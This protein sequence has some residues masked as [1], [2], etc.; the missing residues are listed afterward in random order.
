MKKRMGELQK[1]L[2]A[3]AKQ[4][5]Q[6]DSPSVSD[7]TYDEAM[8]EL[9]SL[10]AQYPQYKAKKSITDSIGYVVLDKFAKEKHTQKM[11]SLGNAYNYEQLLAFDQRVQ[12]EIGKTAYVV[13]L[14]IDGL[15]MSIIYEE[16]K[17]KKAITRGDGV[18]GENV[19]HNIAT[20]KSLPKNISIENMTIRG[21]VY[22]TKKTLEKLN[23]ERLKNNLEP[24]ANC[25][26]AAAGS[27]RQLDSKVA[28]E[29]NLQAFWYQ[30]VDAKNLVDTQ[31][32]MLEK[33]QEEGFSVNPKSKRCNT[34]E[35]VITYIK[36][37]EKQRFDFPYDID[38]IVIKVDNLKNQEKLGNTIKVPK[39][40]IA[41]KFPAEEV[42][43]ILEDIII[44]VGRTGKI[45]PTGKLRPVHIAGT[46]VSAAQLHNFDL[47]EAKDIRIN[48]EVIVRKAGEIIPEIVESKK[49]KR[50]GTQK[51]Y[52]APINC[53]VCDTEIVRDEYEVDYYCLNNDCPARI[54][55]SLIHFASKDAMN[56]DGFGDKI[57]ELFYKEQL[58]KTVEDI[59]LLS[60]K[61]D[62]ILNLPGFKEKSTVK[63]LQA[64][65]NSKK[66]SFTKFI[67]ALGIRNIG[68]KSAGI[69]TKR[70]TTIEALQAADIEDLVDIEDF[71]Y[72][73]AKS[74][75]TF[76]K[77]EKNI[78]LINNLKKLGINMQ[79]EEKT[80]INSI[81]TNKVVVITG[82]FENYSRKEMQEKLENMGAKVT[83]S[84]SNKTDYV[85]Y[86]E[87]AGSKLSKAQALGIQLITENEW[88]EVSTV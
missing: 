61:K 47:I 41:Y 12:K 80:I 74:V 52:E 54:I 34:M 82:T 5:Y 6:E 63:L 38:G 19:T 60:E 86:G 22:L 36:E 16:G 2:L 33:L 58:I 85:I 48:D 17:F 70:Y 62:T 26:N 65:E 42:S 18:I 56:I 81:F 30:I 44:T 72:V 24:F 51:K 87:N 37:I 35:E 64:I 83:S 25:R 9:Q 40:A 46:T 3:W 50:D 53:P 32:E 28:M 78:E 11:Y 66:N 43:S 21:E 31:F 4:Y 68:L 49:E 57:I 8:R 75:A 69:L 1:Q 73:R 20:I 29:R 76:F 84:V 7:A 27:V 23:E 10:E 13:E 15:A 88:E 45:T 59:Y 39:W 55:Q 71:G 67:Y 14:K 79:E 77:N